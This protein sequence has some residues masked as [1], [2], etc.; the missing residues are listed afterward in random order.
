M[1]KNLDE[2]I[3]VLKEE[4]G[5]QLEAN[6]D[7][8]KQSAL[9]SISIQEYKLNVDEAYKKIINLTFDNLIKTTKAEDKQLFLSKA[10]EFVVNDTKKFVVDAE[11]ILL[12]E[13]ERRNINPNGFNPKQYFNDLIKTSK[14]IPSNLINQIAENFVKEYEI[15]SKFNDDEYQRNFFSSESIE[16]FKLKTEKFYYKEFKATFDNLMKESK[17]ELETNALVYLE[18]KLHNEPKAMAERL[19]QDSIIKLKEMNIYVDNFN[20]KQHFEYN[21]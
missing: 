5:K 16:E 14:S 2:L 1:S 21:L 10:K 15:Q 8:L 11:N 19:A 6:E 18:E 4:L 3:K 9:E 12:K 17:S 20:P 7:I 13:L